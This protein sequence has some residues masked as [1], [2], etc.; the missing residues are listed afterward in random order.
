MSIH[1]IVEERKWN[2]WLNETVYWDTTDEILRRTA[3]RRLCRSG[4]IPFL[5]SHGYILNVDET[6][7]GSR[8]A[9]GMYNNRHVGYIE[10]N[11]SFGSVENSCMNSDYQ[12][13]FRHV[14]D[15]DEWEKF[16]TIWGCWGDLD[17]D[18]RYGWDR[19]RDIENYIWSLI[20]A[21]RSRQTLIIREILGED[22]EYETEHDSRDAYLRESAESNEW[23]GYRR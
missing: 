14:I 3:I 21:E 19:Q 18:M 13:H 12:A 7:L 1:R 22:D 4:L 17:K 8:I 16:W 6:E 9:T 2:N 15:I 10:S 20:S 11:W 5:E 23:G